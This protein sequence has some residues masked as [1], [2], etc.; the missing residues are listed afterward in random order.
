MKK[1]GKMIYLGIFLALVSAVSTGVMGG[2]ASLTEE[3]RKNARSAKMTDGLRQVLPAFDNDL[4][5]TKKVY[6][7]SG[8]MRAEVY[9]ARKGNKLVG[10]AVKTATVLG[11]GGTMEGIVSFSPEGKVYTFIITSHQETPGLGAG[12]AERKDARSLKDLLTGKKKE[13]KAFPAHLPGSFVMDQFAGL[14]AAGRPWK[15]KSEGGTIDGVSGATVT[16]RAIADLASRASGVIAGNR[17]AILG[18]SENNRKGT[19]R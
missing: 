8:N 9:T 14:K 4:L 13:K 15:L 19:G 10:V 17:S 1:Y 5:S 3:A 2:I 12:L 6:P 18:R 11:Y 7:A 16:S